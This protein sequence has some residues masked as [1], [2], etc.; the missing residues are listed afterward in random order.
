MVQTLTTFTLTTEYSPNG[1]PC[2]G[3]APLLP[4]LTAATPASFNAIESHLSN[5]SNPLHG[6]SKM[7]HT[8]SRSRTALQELPPHLADP[9]HF[10]PLVQQYPTLCSSPNER[11][12]AIP[13]L[14]VWWCF[15]GPAQDLNLSHRDYGLMITHSWSWLDGAQKVMTS[16][17]CPLHCKG[18][19]WPMTNPHRGP[20]DQLCVQV[21]CQRSWWPR[22]KLVSSSD[23]I[24]ADLSSPGAS[25]TFLRI[26]SSDS[27]SRDP[28]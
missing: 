23:H 17:H 2:S 28:A 16:L 5:T 4:S 15:L 3:I 10:L 6:L 19:P 27:A 8:R 18:S 1:S 24:L 11:S 20:G 22:L 21:M 12:C 13:L 9:V 26:P 25:F 14:Q 7:S